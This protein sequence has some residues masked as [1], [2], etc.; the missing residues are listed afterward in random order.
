MMYDQEFLTDLSKAMEKAYN[1]LLPVK[2]QTDALEPEVV[3]EIMNYIYE[4]A[5]FV[6]NELEPNK[7]QYMCCPCAVRGSVDLIDL[8]ELIIKLKDEMKSL[9]SDIEKNFL[10]DEFTSKMFKMNSISLFERKLGFLLDKDSYQKIANYV[11]SNN[12]NALNTPQIH[13]VVHHTAFPY[14]MKATIRT[15]DFTDRLVTK[16]SV[17]TSTFAPY[18]YLDIEDFKNDDIHG[19]KVKNYTNDYNILSYF[20]HYSA[21]LNAQ[22][23]DLNDLQDVKTVIYG[24]ESVISKVTDKDLMFHEYLKFTFD[25]ELAT[26]SYN[27]RYFMCEYEGGY[28]LKDKTKLDSQALLITKEESELAKITEKKSC[29]CRHPVRKY[30]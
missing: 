23:V 6:E 19:I 30:F 25:K 12:L 20:A 11:E 26:T 16:N 24:E 13:L 1:E 8:V 18:L 22:I 17:Y 28:L 9:A 4:T 3:V 7:R 2:E 21:N 27:D 5:D 15:K 14:T 29:N 10:K